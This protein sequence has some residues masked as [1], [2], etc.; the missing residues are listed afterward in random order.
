MSSEN[1]T[2]GASKPDERPPSEPERW[3]PWEKES[4]AH[5]IRA[6][7]RAQEATNSYVS[8]MRRENYTPADIEIAVSVPMTEA[9]DAAALAKPEVLA[10]L[11]LDLPPVWRETFMQ[12]VG[13]NAVWSM[14]GQPPFF[15]D[16]LRGQL[17]DLDNEWDKWW[18][19]HRRD[20]DIPDDMPLWDAQKK[21]L[22][23]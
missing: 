11:H 17:F 3:A 5:F 16:T 13:M 18:S 22:G 1:Y 8:L 20:L 10:K 9:R 4:L 7:S 14:A 23:R 19:S 15:D 21:D 2:S 6:M 12:V